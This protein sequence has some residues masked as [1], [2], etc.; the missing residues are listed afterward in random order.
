ME[1]K[2]LPLRKRKLRSSEENKIQALADR[3]KDL[4]DKVYKQS[5]LVARLLKLLEKKR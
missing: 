3:V 1:A 2:I 4:E 5:T